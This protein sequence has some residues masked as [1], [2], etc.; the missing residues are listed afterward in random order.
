MS[1]ISCKECYDAI[2]LSERG[3]FLDDS[4]HYL[5]LHDD[6]LSLFSVEESKEYM[7]ESPR[8]NYLP[9]IKDEPWTPFDIRQTLRKVSRLR[10]REHLFTDK[11]I[12][13]VSRILKILLTRLAREIQ[14]FSKIFNVCTRNEVY[15]ATQVIFNK[16]VSRA[17]IGNS[18][19]AYY[20]YVHSINRNTEKHLRMSKSERSGLDI[21]VGRVFRWMVRNNLANHISDSAAVYFTA[22]L[23][24]LIEEIC[25]LSDQA[26]NKKKAGLVA[27]YSI[28]A[29]DIIVS[30]SG[31][32]DIWRAAQVY[33]HL[34]TVKCTGESPFDQPKEMFFQPVRSFVREDNKTCNTK[35]FASREEVASII[36]KASVFDLPDTPRHRSVRRRSSPAILH[37]TKKTSDGIPW[38]NSAID[39]LFEFTKCPRKRFPEDG[40]TDDISQSSP[41]LESNPCED[42]HPISEWVR[43]CGVFAKSRLG[44]CIDADDVKQAARVLLPSCFCL[45]REAWP[46]SES[47]QPSLSQL[48]EDEMVNSPAKAHLS[49]PFFMKTL[50]DSK[51]DGERKRIFAQYSS[52]NL[53]RHDSKGMTILMYASLHGNKSLC[54]DLIE[55][56]VN[57]NARVPFDAQENDCIPA[58]IKGWSA[59]SF[60]VTSGHGEI[61][62][63]LLENGAIPDD[64]FIPGAADVLSP[65]HLAAAAGQFT[66]FTQLLSKR[67][68]TTLVSKELEN[69]GAQDADENL[70]KMHLH[71][72]AAAHG[73]RRTL[74]KLLSVPDQIR[75][76]KPGKRGN[77][78]LVEALSEE[79]EE[80]P[81]EETDQSRRKILKEAMYE[82]AEHGYVHIALEIRSLDTPWNYHTWITTLAY[83]HEYNDM[84]AVQCLLLDFPDIS[85]AELSSGINERHACMF[86]EIFRDN[87]SSSIQQVASIISMFYGETPKID[88]RAVEED[89]TNNLPKIGTKFVNSKEMADIIFNIEGKPFY[90]H[91]IILQN[92]SKRLE[93]L[94]RC[95]DDKGEVNIDGIKYSVFEAA[96]QFLYSG[97]VLYQ[98]QPDK[99]LELLDCAAKLQLPSLKQTCEFESAR[100]MT[101][102][103][104]V[105]VYLS[106]KACKAYQ[107]EK[108]CYH[109]FLANLSLMVSRDEF[110]NLLDKNKNIFGYLEQEFLQSLLGKQTDS[111]NIVTATYL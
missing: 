8:Y 23:E 1:S 44:K 77:L 4:M 104:A 26:I 48:N 3:G 33:E 72:L 38:T 32:P 86:F 30:L 53:N 40:E 31:K 66:I 84:E 13:E 107:L 96:M 42:A 45:A 41:V 105:D 35:C 99:V 81:E 89:H 5:S 98:S 57:L 106:S 25:Y 93:E 90:A 63:T 9:D 51:H 47:C 71:G 34:S 109:F 29:D 60:A 111:A 7:I 56:R 103:N 91:K 6:E 80:V 22:I 67:V 78:S 85:D 94:T 55:R 16:A 37:S 39:T 46:S 62:K 102:Y 69:H 17:C 88:V 79:R 101:S 97:G 68:N 74:R 108:Y 43:V 19:Q 65:L 95:V 76:E 73:R 28:L 58:T 110:V 10:N 36:E 18:Y 50:L 24:Y 14:R 12:T 59:L 54:K 82:S 21:S 2:M 61:V 100:H 20:L 52:Q 75:I 83:A 49:N 27:N 87:P 92:A 64:L 11:A 15:S 70:Q